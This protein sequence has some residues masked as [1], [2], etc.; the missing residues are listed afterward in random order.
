M[1]WP[2]D[3]VAEFV[4]RQKILE[5]VN[6]NPDL[7]PGAID[8]YSTRPVGFI[9]DWCVTYD[10]RNAMNNL[11]T[12]MPFLLFSR[13]KEY[14]NFIISCADV[15][16]PALCE[17]SRDMGATWLS[18]VVSVW[19]WRFKAGSSIGWGSR[20][21]NLVDRL[22]DPDSIIEK[23]RMII[24]YLPRWLWPV[25]F[26]RKEH[27]N[28]MKIVNPENGA[29]IT[30]EAG[31]EIGR[32][33]RKSI[34]FKDESAH[35]ERPERIEA[36]LSENTDVPVDISSVCGVSNIFHRKR[37]AG[38][39]WEPG[40]KIDKK[41]FKFLSST[42]V[43]I[44]RKIKSGMIIKKCDIVTRDLTIYSLKRLIGIIVRPLKEFLFRQSGLRLLSV[45]ILNYVSLL[46]GL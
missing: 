10:P 43:I 3:Y 27:M 37:M 33:G 28:F 17:K 1:K 2:P 16:V 45:P 35:Y 38:E 24:D 42:G 20:K 4:R 34:F 36:A 9:E 25:G 31:D 7:I 19:L 21:E 46:R 29:T 6:K 13:Q 11:P 40:K 14:V 12:I 22:G 15:G 5:S 32:G 41:K 26:S 30:G 39:I 8:Y 18:C 44:R 23:I